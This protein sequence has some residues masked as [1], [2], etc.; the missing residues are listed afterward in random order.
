M[1][2]KQLLFHCR[3]GHHYGWGHL[4]RCSALAIEARK[5]GLTTYLWSPD[6]AQQLPA[7]IL[8]DFDTILNEPPVPA[9]YAGLVLDN[10]EAT[11]SVVAAF[12]PVGE[13]P[14]VAVDDAGTRDL[15]FAH[16]IVNPA[17]HAPAD[18]YK[19]SVAPQPILCLGPDYALLRES[20]VQMRHT[21]RQQAARK[22]DQRSGIAI[23][24]GGTDVLNLV[25]TLLDYLLDPSSPFVNEPIHLITP[26]RAATRDAI[27]EHQHNK[28]NLHW[29]S[30]A[31]AEQ[32][33]QLMH[34]CRFGITACGGTVY[35]MASCEL[36]FVGIVVADNQIAFAQAVEKEWLLPILPGTQLTASALIKSLLRL[37]QVPENYAEVDGRGAVRVFNRLNQHL[38][39]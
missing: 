35:E 1:K 15:S 8:Q 21:T 18:A 24:V 37:E 4:V 25:P 28:K 22:R 34:K 5:R 14:I 3:Y 17:L 30:Q 38:S 36:P 12:W 32:L 31:S 13:R 33:A 2:A 11:Q 10:L 6:A 20:F 26:I 27:A 23:V 9:N 19:Y 7:V 16:M 29:H 39:L